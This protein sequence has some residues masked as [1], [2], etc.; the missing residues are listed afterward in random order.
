MALILSYWWY[1]KSK[2]KTID[3]SVSGDAIF[4]SCYLPPYK[5]YLSS[6]ISLINIVLVL[7]ICY[8][9]LSNIKIIKLITKSNTPSFSQFN[10]C[11]KSCESYKTVEKQDKNRKARRK[12]WNTRM[13]PHVAYKQKTA[14]KK[15]GLHTPF[16][17]TIQQN[18]LVLRTKLVTTLTTRILAN[19]E[20]ISTMNV[21]HVSG[22]RRSHN[23]VLGMITFAIIFVKP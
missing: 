6:I 18:Q 11:R 9:N 13:Q 3:P 10:T 19:S 17:W 4:A 5:S 23:Y 7:F 20:I 1:W 14:I 22:Y 16:E 15:S 12:R 2:L 21:P 8:E